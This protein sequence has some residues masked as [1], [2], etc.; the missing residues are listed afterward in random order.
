MIDFLTIVLAIF[1]V[2]QIILFFK[3][4]GMTNDVDKIKRKLETQPKEEDAIII[5]A[6]LN[7]LNGD[8]EK[9][10]ELYK[11]AFHLSLIELYNKTI[12]EY[13][14][15]DESEYDARNEYYTSSYKNI[16]KYYSKRF[17]KLKIKFEF[18]Q[19]DSY[20]KANNI[21]CKI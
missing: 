3:M 20:N 5:E 8:N 9:A 21:L 16:V 17:K 11:K 10:F 1:G 15:E 4:W 18:E 2:L 6:Q 14:S 19:F 13:G 12:S 7:S